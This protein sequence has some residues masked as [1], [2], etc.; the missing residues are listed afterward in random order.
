MSSH[1]FNYIYFNFQSKISYK[2][3]SWY[4]VAFYVS[5]L[6]NLYATVP[7]FLELFGCIFFC[8]MDND[9]DII[10]IVILQKN[11]DRCEISNYLYGI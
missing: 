9:K 4:L 8:C 10:L 11:K 2:P 5:I 6:R 3:Y 7:T 1:K